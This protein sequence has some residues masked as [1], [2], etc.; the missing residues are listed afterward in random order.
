MAKKKPRLEVSRSLYATPG[1]LLFYVDPYNAWRK[2]RAQSEHTITRDTPNLLRF[3][4]YCEERAVHTPAEVGRPF[5]ERYQRHLSREVKSD[6]K[7]LSVRAQLGYLL[8][9]RGFFR[10][11][12][13][14]R[15]L[16][17]NPSS[18]LLLPRVGKRLPRFVL[19]QQEAE[20]VLSTPDIADPIGLRDRALLE[21]LYSTGIRRMEVVFLRRIDMDLVGLTVFVHQGKGKK[22]RVVPIGERAALW[23]RKYLAEAYPKLCG[24]HVPKINEDFVFLT[25]AGEHIA[26]NYLTEIVQKYVLK[27]GIGK[28]GSCHLFR[29]TMATLMLEGGADVR[30]V[31]AMLGHS[32]L[33]TTEIYTHV[34]IGK[35]KEVHAK[36][37]PAKAY[38]TVILPHEENSHESHL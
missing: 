30:Y 6:G 19:T 16:M 21:V 18:D 9:V 37:H 12:C 38:R 25:A 20:L 36:S 17:Y 35:L 2:M 7:D 1:T 4:R 10:Y 5:I 32:Q 23:V 15:I 28:P 34:S 33:S 11:L 3:I 26:P 8:S 24:R 14:E 31:Q 13:R 29:H 22:D 27:S